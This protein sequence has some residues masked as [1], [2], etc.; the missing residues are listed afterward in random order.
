MSERQP[1]HLVAETADTVTLRRSDFEALLDELEDAEDSVAL[2]QRNLEVAKGDYTPALTVDE[3]NRLMT[4]ENRVKVWRQKTGLS[5]RQ[6][7][8]Y[9]EV[10]QSLLAEIETGV[11]TGGVDTLKKLARAMKISLDALTD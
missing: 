5:Q 1:I 11:K 9:A 2:L 8:E 4:G 10:S 3:L 7:A 6:L